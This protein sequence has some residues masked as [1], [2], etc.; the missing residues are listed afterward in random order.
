MKLDRRGSVS[1]DQLARR[2]R[3]YFIDV[4]ID[5]IAFRALERVDRNRFWRARRESAS[6]RRHTLCRCSFRETVWDFDEHSAWRLLG[7]GGSATLSVTDSCRSRCGDTKS[8]LP[9]CPG[10]DIKALRKSATNGQQ[11]ADQAGIVPRNLCRQVDV[12]VANS[13]LATRS[14]SRL[15]CRTEAIKDFQ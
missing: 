3:T 15:E 9:L 14:K 13:G 12:S 4:L 11:L 2:C 10:V 1:D 8:K 7:S 5:V 6:S